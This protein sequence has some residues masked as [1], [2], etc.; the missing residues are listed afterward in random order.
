MAQKWVK[1]MKI[2]C[3]IQHKGNLKQNLF[4]YLK[5]KF[6]FINLKILGHQIQKVEKIFYVIPKICMK[7]QIKE[8][9]NQYLDVLCSFYNAMPKKEVKNLKKL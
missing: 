7:Q 4:N 6:I 1:I 3:L 8:T 5:T 2:L 9:C